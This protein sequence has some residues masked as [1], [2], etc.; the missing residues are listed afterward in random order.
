MTET[1]VL[2]KVK[3]KNIVKLAPNM[4][5]EDK[6]ND[7]FSVPGRT[8]PID[9]ETLHREEEEL[10]EAKRAT[11]PKQS[12]KIFNAMSMISV[13]IDF[14]VMIAAPLIIFIYA[15]TWLDTRKGTKYWVIVGIVLALVTSTVGIRKQIIKLKDK[16]K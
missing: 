5:D 14:A 11:N 15:G 16:I 3:L 2:A 9:L 13:G 8:H 7:Q 4:S 6:K 10:R 12:P 1:A